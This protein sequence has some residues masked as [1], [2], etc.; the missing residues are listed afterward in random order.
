[1]LQIDG[2]PM[3]AFCSNDYLG[4]AS[5]PALATAA[6]EAAHA[7]GLGS[8]GSP[9]VSGHST[10]NALLEHDLARAVGLPIGPGHGVGVGQVAGHGVEAL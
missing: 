4:L 1:M 5:H 3:L 2:Q 8:G 7:Y 6:A 10:A 9:L